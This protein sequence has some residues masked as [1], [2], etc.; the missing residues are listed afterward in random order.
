[1]GYHDPH[2][3]FWSV[4]GSRGWPEAVN[5]GQERLVAWSLASDGRTAGT[6][7]LN[8]GVRVLDLTTPQPARV[9]RLTTPGLLGAP[10][11]S[12]GGR[13]AVSWDGRLVAAFA[14]FRRIR[15]WEVATGKPVATLPVPEYEHATPIQLAFGAGNERLYGQSPGELRAWDTATWA[16]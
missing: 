3:R 14:G 1:S 9:I 16:V 13:V 7:D 11:W 8:G 4:T 5:T 2:L 12:A 6:V 15:V 10:Y